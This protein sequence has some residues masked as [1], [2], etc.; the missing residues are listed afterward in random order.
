VL[1]RIRGAPISDLL[2]LRPGDEVVAGPWQVATS[3][4][5]K[6]GEVSVPI[7]WAALDCAGYASFAS[8][9]DAAVL[10]RMTAEIDRPPSVGERCTVVGWSLGRERRKRFAATALYGED[11]TV[12]A[13]AAQVWIAI[14][15]SPAVT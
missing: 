6:S 13:R 10:G 9:G 12:L 3:V 15:R 1:H 14:D 2:H 8:A 5:D 7:V 11:G 4:A